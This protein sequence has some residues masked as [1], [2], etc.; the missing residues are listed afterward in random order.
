MG[1]TDATVAFAQDLAPAFG[2]CSASSSLIRRETSQLHNEWKS[3]PNRAQSSTPDNLQTDREPTLRVFARE[4]PEV[5]RKGFAGGSLLYPT[6]LYTSSCALHR[7]LAVAF[8][9]VNHDRNLIRGRI[10]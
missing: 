9:Q 4:K 5:K 1:Q 7:Q 8:E 10:V 2:R 6:H 3:T